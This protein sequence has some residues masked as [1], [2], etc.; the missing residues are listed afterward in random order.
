MTLS[1]QVHPP[2]L[3]LI[4][5]GEQV[6]LTK[7]TCITSILIINN[8]L[9]YYYCWLLVGER[10]DRFMNQFLIFPIQNFILKKIHF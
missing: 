8:L 6:Q 2:L 5:E 7:H 4:N 1:S 9:Y 10:T 3:V